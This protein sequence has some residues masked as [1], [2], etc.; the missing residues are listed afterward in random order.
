MESYGNKEQSNL[1]HSEEKMNWFFEN[2]WSL[3]VTEGIKVLTNMISV[4]ER[5]KSGNGSNSKTNE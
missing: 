2:I 3:S 1:K 5:E 4:L